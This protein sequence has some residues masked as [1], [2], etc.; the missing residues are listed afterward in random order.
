[1]K[2]NSEGQPGPQDY[3]RTHADGANVLADAVAP[4]GGI[5]MWRAFVYN[6]DVDPDRVKR[7]YCRVRAARRE[8]PRQRLRAGEERPA[9]LP[10]ARAVS[11]DVRRHAED[12]AD[13]G[14]A[15]HAGVPGAVQPSRVSGADVE[16]VPRRRHVCEG[17][18]VAVSRTSIDGSLDG[19]PDTGIAGVANTGLDANWTGHDLAQAELVRVRTAGLEPA[20]WAPARS[21][22]NGSA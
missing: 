17:P 18:G 19:K 21:P 3:G 4:H 15:D 2:A 10:A 9:R 13:G 20:A 5:V 11:S 14:A 8:V 12:A 16:G 7:A 6:A 1:M 22:T